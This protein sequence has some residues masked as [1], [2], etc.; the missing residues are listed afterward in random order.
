MAGLDLLIQ[1]LD[2]H[3]CRPI[4]SGQKWRSRCPAHNSRGLTLEV[5]AGRKGPLVRCYAGCE[6]TEVFDSLGLKWGDL[7]DG[8][9]A[10]VVRKRK[11][12][13]HLEKA[14]RSGSK[15]TRVGEGVYS[16]TCRCG[17]NLYVG[18]VGAA[19]ER[20]CQISSDPVTPQWENPV[21]LARV[22]G[23]DDL[24]PSGEGVF[25]GTCPSCGGWLSAGPGGASC[26]SNCPVEEVGSVVRSL[27][28]LTKGNDMQKRVLEVL[29]CVEKKRGEKNGRM[30]VLYAVHANDENGQPIQHELTSFDLLPEGRGEYYVQS[31]ETQYGVQYSVKRT[32]SIQE[33]N[34]DEIVSLLKEILN[35]VA[36]GPLPPAT[37]AAQNNVTP[38]PKP[39][40]VGEVPF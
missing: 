4:Q 6:Y 7:V 29:G 31:K 39:V 40:E 25:V 30:W 11:W 27:R 32:L 19:C 14:V 22:F 18:S 20:G 8:D 9:F 37:V 17:G 2:A 13:R 15:P 5:T 35:H 12:E 10:P 1:T 28:D 38:M 36:R 33:K 3:D 34:H 16:G 21:E 24:K 23:C 26:E